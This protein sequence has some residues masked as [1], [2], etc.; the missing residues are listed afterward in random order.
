MYALYYADMKQIL[1][2]VIIFVLGAASY[3]FL[4]PWLMSFL[5][6]DE[7]DVVTKD[8]A[9][10]TQEKNLVVPPTTKEEPAQKPQVSVDAQGALHDGPFDLFAADGTKIGGTVEIIRSPEETLLQ[11]K[12]AEVKHSEES[13]IYFAADKQA[14]KYFNLG[15]AKLSSGVMVYG[16]PLDADLSAYSYILIYDVYDNMVEYYAEIK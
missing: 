14:K 6:K 2:L 16:M 10:T 13:N 3:S 8:T 11:F 9:T 1:L 4:N 7:A 5:N 12:N 15:L